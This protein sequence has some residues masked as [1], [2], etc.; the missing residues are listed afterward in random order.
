MHFNH[1][2]VITHI[3]VRTALTSWEDSIIHAFLKIRRVL[4]VL[5]E[6]NKT[7]TRPTKSLM[8]KRSVRL[9]F[10]GKC[11]YIRRSGHDITMLEGTIELLRSDE[12]TCVRDIGHQPCSFP[13]GSFLELGV[14]P[15]AWVCR[16]TANDEARLKDFRL[17]REARVID[18]VAARFDCVG[19]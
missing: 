1:E 16:G 7:S 14:V 6:E 19:K 13:R 17:R 8:T 12:T 10:E 11:R 3:V 18:Q 15:V 5:S 2:R 9:L 4:K